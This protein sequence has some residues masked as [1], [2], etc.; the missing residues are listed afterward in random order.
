MRLPAT[1][2][3]EPV[4]TSPTAVGNYKRRGLVLLATALLTTPIHN[5]AVASEAAPQIETSSTAP[6]SMPSPAAIPNIPPVPNFDGFS[7]IPKP[8]N[9]QCDENG[10]N[11]KFTGSAGKNAAVADMVGLYVPVDMDDKGGLFANIEFKN[12]KSKQ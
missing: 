9:L 4:A 12:G 11:C 3:L 10:R 5:A 8:K 1:V 7:L 2:H 6:L